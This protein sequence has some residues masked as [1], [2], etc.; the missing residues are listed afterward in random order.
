[1]AMNW[2][3]AGEDSLANGFI[4]TLLDTEDQ[5]AQ[6]F[7]QKS[8]IFSYVRRSIFVRHVS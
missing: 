6:E 3:M 2:Q 5:A 8:V 7:L 4:L 1:M